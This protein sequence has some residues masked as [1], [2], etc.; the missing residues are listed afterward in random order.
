MKKAIYEQE[1]TWGVHTV[2]EGCGK[3]AGKF[4]AQSRGHGGARGYF[5]VF[6]TADAATAHIDSQ[7]R[8]IRQ[9]ERI[10]L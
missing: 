2:T 7:T 6:D 1:T 5:R 9:D 8:P 10:S 4:I 3:Y